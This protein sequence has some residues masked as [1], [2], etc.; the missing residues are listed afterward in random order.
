MTGGLALTAITS[1]AA[2]VAPA[3]HYAGFWRRVVAFAIDHAIILIPMAIILYAIGA[4]RILTSD[5][6]IAAET[7]YVDFLNKYSLAL[8]LLYFAV[9]WLYYALL[10]S[11]PRQATLGKRILGIKVT[12]MEG[13]RLGFGRS[14]GRQLGKMVSKAS[15]GIGF[16]VA[17]FTP[18]KQAL[19]DLFARCLVVCLH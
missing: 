9:V 13:R 6:P 18:K 17:A 16:V 10:E 11:G 19:H 14:L 8:P 4:A 7:A 15:L 1:D 3:V 2:L 12:D 5:D